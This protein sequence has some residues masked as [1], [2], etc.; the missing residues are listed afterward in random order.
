VIGALRLAHLGA[1]TIGIAAVF[2][3][4]AGVGG[5]VA[6]WAGR[7]VDRFGAERPIRWGLVTAAVVL[8]LTAIAA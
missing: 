2:L 5:A 4:A 1:G 8:S 6:P 7:L 3:I